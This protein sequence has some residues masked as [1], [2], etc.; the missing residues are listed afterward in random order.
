MRKRI[1]GTGCCLID[2]LYLNSSFEEPPLADFLSHKAG[3][4]GLVPGNLVFS[5]DLASFAGLNER[6]C[7]KIVTG[8]RKA[9]STNLG[10]PGVVSM[11]HAS[12]ILT[13]EGWEC[14]FYGA[15][16]NDSGS[17]VL[18]DFLNKFPLT[19]SM[20]Q[21]NNTVIPSTIVLSDP[22]ANQGAGERTFINRLGS[23]ELMKPDYLNDGFFDASLF[24]WGGTA[25]VPPIHDN[26]TELLKKASDR[27][28]IN[29]VGTVYDFRNESAAPHS[30]WPL[31][32]RGSRE[33]AYPYIDLLITDYEEALRL[34]G[35]DSLEKATAF[36]KKCGCGAF[37][38]TRG[39]EDFLLYSQGNLFIPCGEK[40]LPVSSWV[41]Q[42]L[43]EHPEL[44][45]D[46]TGCG[47]NFMGGVLTS[48][49]RQLE[50]QEKTGKKPD[51]VKA[52]VEGA[53][54]GGLAL[55]S[56]GGCFHEAYGGEKADRLLPIRE[57]Y[58]RE[59]NL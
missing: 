44:R 54:A 40:Y 37:I 28:G 15:L 55:Y 59:V 19:C 29:V 57:A 53:C 22:G 56:R 43:K 25:L 18:K 26:L 7:I 45:G 49:A 16:S 1:S 5:K 39:K 34:S 42:D 14:T 36:F 6:E 21:I 27:G 20:E 13:R 31:G 4:G 50:N 30:P 17:Q 9:D 24:L 51:L 48:L 8:N 2:Y 33:Q 11:V 38:I 3:D 47:D 58:L 46:T 10:G 41:D 23:A 12:Q 32:A 35:T 52:C